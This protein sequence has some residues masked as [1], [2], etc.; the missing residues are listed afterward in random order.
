MFLTN[1]GSAGIGLAS[2]MATTSKAIA[3]P[4]DDETA[5]FTAGSS[6]GPI[7]AGSP[8]VSG[9]A[10]DSI[11]ILQPIQRYATGYLEFASPV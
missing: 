1:T 9:P 5:R 6:P 11:T 2:A 4:S 8:V 10:S 3:L 7:F